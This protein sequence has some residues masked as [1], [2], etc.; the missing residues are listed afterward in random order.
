MEYKVPKVL[1]SKP[2][3]AGFGI[4]FVVII[5]VGMILFVFAAVN[6]FVKALPIPFVLGL[7]IYLNLKFKNFDAFVKFLSYHISA[8][9][10]IQDKNLKQL[11]KDNKSS[12][13]VKNEAN[14]QQ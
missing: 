2:T 9:C 1:E 3:V 14:N 11:M 4:G 8:N 10:V 6:D 12:L 13:Y 7:L 5:V